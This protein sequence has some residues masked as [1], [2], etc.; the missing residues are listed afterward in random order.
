MTIKAICTKVA[1]ID[2][3]FAYYYFTNA[4]DKS[5]TFRAKARY[6]GIVA[7]WIVDESYQFILDTHLP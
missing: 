4:E 6:G 7:T 1:P 5:M 2:K 3:E